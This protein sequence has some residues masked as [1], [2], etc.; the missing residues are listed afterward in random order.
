MAVLEAEDMK[1]ILRLGDRT[2]LFRLQRQGS[3]PKL[4]DP[5][6]LAPGLEQ[7]LAAF[8]SRFFG[9]LCRHRREALPRFEARDRGLR[10]SLGQLPM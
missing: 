2:D 10:F 3:D 4:G 8:G 7:P 1:A 5:G 9:K 6:A